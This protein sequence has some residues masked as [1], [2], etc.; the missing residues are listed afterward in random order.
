MKVISPATDERS[1]YVTFYGSIPHL[2]MS[3][4][5]SGPSV[6]N[7]Q[8][9]VQYREILYRARAELSKARQN[10]NRPVCIPRRVTWL[11]DMVQ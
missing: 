7:L 4:Q 10:T 6:H 9:M 8:F 1:R 2:F 3:P 11:K 5:F